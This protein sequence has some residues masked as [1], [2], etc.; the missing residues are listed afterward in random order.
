MTIVDDANWGAGRP[1]WTALAIGN[2]V[3]SFCHLGARAPAACVALVILF[4]PGMPL[5]AKDEF[6]VDAGGAFLH[7]PVDGRVQTPAGGNLGSTSPGRPTFEELGIK[8]VRAADFWANISRG[9][10]GLYAGGRIMRLAGGGTLDDTLI[11]QNLL[12]A[13]GLPV[14]AQAKFDWYRV[15]YRYLFP[16]DWGDKTIELYPSIGAA[17]LDFHYTL[18]SP[19]LEGVDRSY[20]KVG[21]QIGLGVTLPLT[22]HLSLTGQVLAPIPFSH[23][24]EILSAQVTMK[25][26]LLER[27]DL[28]ISGVFGIA[29]DRISYTDGQ[30]VPNDIEADMGPMGLLGLEIRF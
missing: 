18:S 29:Y 23:A 15:G 21:A 24:P 17:I 22:E 10:H 27:R 7:G 19:G 26:R 5:S 14:E 16:W 28:S 4:A 8:S 30:T 6:R 1:L 2:I 13:A 20:M 3:M 9:R 11:S 12:F 25:Y